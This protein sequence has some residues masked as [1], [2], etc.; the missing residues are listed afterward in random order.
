ML[1]RA[2]FFNLNIFLNVNDMWH[3]TSFINHVTSNDASMSSFCLSC[4]Q[5]LYDMQLCDP[6]FGPVN[7]W[8]ILQTEKH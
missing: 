7:T 3:A 5:K 8:T 2:T 1:S 6:T 4:Q